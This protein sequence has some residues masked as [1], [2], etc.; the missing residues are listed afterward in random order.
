[1]KGRSTI[2]ASP[3]PKFLRVG[4]YLPLLLVLVCDKALPATL[5]DVLLYLSSERILEAFEATDLLVCFLFIHTTSFHVVCIH[6]TICCTYCQQD[7]TSN[8]VNFHN[9]I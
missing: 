4:A 7:Y 9:W 6:D 2:N 1:M 5:L 3:S 8:S